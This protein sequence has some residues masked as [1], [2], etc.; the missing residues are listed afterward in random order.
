MRW[1][2]YYTGL[3]GTARIREREGAAKVYSLDWDRTVLMPMEIP[4]RSHNWFVIESP[5]IP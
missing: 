5:L 4:P 1:P 3:T 2:L